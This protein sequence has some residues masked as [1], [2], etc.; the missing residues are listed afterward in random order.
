MLAATVATQVV[1]AT[2]AHADG[3]Y[4]WSRTLNQGT[5]GEDVRQLQIRV[6]GYPAYGEHIATDGIFGPATKAAVQRFQTAYGLTAD[7]IAT[8]ATYSKIYALQ[9]DDCTPIHFT[10]A[11]LDDGCGGSGYDGGPLSEAATKANALQTMW[12][13]EALR[14][15][16]GDQALNI[17]SG[18]RSVPC[19]NSVGGASNSQHLYGRSADLTGVH[20]F[21][22]MA[23]RARYHGFGGIFG[24]GYPGHDDHTHIDIRTS[25]SWSA[26]NCGI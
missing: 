22:T 17:S 24:P 11:E 1:T 16:L 19:N 5:S 14:H 6:A 23:K 20:S 26:P 4:T 25:N 9:D 7:G 18:F 13:L 21:C 15:A 8:A 12:Q 2:K 10:Y 3:C